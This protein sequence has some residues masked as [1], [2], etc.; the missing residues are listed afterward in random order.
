MCVF[1]LDDDHEAPDGPLGPNIATQM[2]F[3][4]DSDELAIH[5]HARY[6][7]PVVE[8]PRFIEL[9]QDPTRSWIRIDVARIHCLDMHWTSSG[10]LVLG[11][12][13]K[14]TLVLKEPHCD[15]IRQQ[16]LTVLKSAQPE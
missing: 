9:L 12:G 4:L 7:W 6:L 15:R 5:Y 13:G 11:T 3:Q 8:L 14:H 16:L 2:D 10:R 1:T